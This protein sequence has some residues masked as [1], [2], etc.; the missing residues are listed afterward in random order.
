MCEGAGSPAEINL[1]DGDIANLAVAAAAGMRALLVGDIE[2]GG[3]FAALYGTM[4]LLPEELATGSAALSSTSS[5]ATPP[6]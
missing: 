4:A 5:A 3:V 6:C 1:L 2:R